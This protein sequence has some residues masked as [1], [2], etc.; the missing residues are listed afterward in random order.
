MRSVPVVAAVIER[1]G[2]YLLGRRPGH[3]RHGDLWEFPG[4]KM[5]HGEDYLAAARRELREELELSAQSLGRLLFTA[6]DSGSAFVI[7][8]VEVEVAGEP[9]AREH[10]AVGWFTPPELLAMPLAP[11][12]AR[13]VR[14]LMGATD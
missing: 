14:H 7:H 3:K 9:D 4:G 2:R 10:T 6:E 8:F 11:S 12:D 1:E 5:H 13:F